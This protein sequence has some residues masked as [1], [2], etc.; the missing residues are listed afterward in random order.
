[1]MYSAMM[2]VLPMGINS[3]HSISTPR[4]S[5]GDTIS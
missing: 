3:P 1:M 4:H 5:S 2:T